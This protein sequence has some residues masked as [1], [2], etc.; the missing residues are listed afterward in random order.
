MPSRRRVRLA[1]LVSGV[2]TLAA[3][4]LG[5]CAGPGGDGRDRAAEAR[6]GTPT[7]G[8][9]PA[10]PATAGPPGARQAS[11]ALPGQVRLASGREYVLPRPAPARLGARRPLLLV[12]H[13]FGGT[14]R[15]MEHL[16]QFQERAARRGYVV[17]YGI[18][19]RRSWDAA[20]CCGWSNAHRAKDVEYLTDVVADVRRRV[21]GIDP[22]RIYLTG[23]SN[24]AM[25][26]LHALCERPRLFAAGVGVAGALVGRCRGGAPIH[27]LE[28]HGTSD[29]V[30]PYDGGRTD[31]LHAT[32]PPVSDLPGTI[33]DRAP[34]SVVKIRSH[35]CGHVWPVGGRCHLDAAAIG[36]EFLRRYALPSPPHHAYR[37]GTGR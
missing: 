22:R 14:W 4:A 7:T 24:G 35:P 36:W 3:T 2:L 25:M 13:S 11:A 19:A 17:A 5:G 31:W 28:I 33:A 8:A 16:G 1:A 37:T 29:A 10:S 6:V 23:F 26:T 18:G 34:G 20:G 27:Y 21:P 30:V 15:R 32:F 12:L 9:T